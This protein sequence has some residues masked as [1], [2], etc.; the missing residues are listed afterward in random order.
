MQHFCREYQNLSYALLEILDRIRCEKA[1]QVVRA[2]WQPNLQLHSLYH[3]LRPHWQIQPQPHQKA[4]HHWQWQ[5]SKL[6]N[7]IP[8]DHGDSRIMLW[9]FEIVN[10]IVKMGSVCWEGQGRKRMDIKPPPMSSLSPPAP[11]WTPTRSSRWLSGRWRI[12]KVW[13]I[14]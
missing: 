4:H 13:N 8:C 1:P 9:R 6:W 2:W 5:S 14:Y 11:V 10:K 7:R 3:K 12:R